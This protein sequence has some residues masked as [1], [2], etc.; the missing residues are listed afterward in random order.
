MMFNQYSLYINLRQ[1]NIHLT[2][3][4]I[5]RKFH[6]KI[7]VNKKSLFN[8]FFKKSNESDG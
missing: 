7:E 1:Q 5:K 2:L 8:N 4:E 3:Q 6:L